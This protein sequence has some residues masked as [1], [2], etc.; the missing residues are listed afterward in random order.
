MTDVQYPWYALVSGD[1]LEQG[2]I[3]ESC[4]VFRPPQELV[5]SEAL[6]GFF[7]AEARNVVVISQ[8][9]DLVKGREKLSE[10]LFCPLW[11]L[12]QFAPG[13]QLSTPKGREEARR[14]HLPSI[15]ML[16]DCLLPGF[17][18]PLRIVD[19]RQLFTLPLP[20]A[21]SQ[22]GAADQRLRLLPPYRE[23]LA[24]AFARYFMRVGLPLDIP[25]LR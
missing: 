3:L 13:H 1:D 7:E 21:R 12:S 25:P 8:S 5:S 9:C 16:S 11:D 2:D 4:P 19:F 20:F 6:S 24:Q 17:K 18:R 23:H 10:V 14:G 15:H 22:A